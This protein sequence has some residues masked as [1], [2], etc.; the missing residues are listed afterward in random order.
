MAA[1]SLHFYRVIQVERYMITFWR[2]V[3][4]LVK[5]RYRV[6]VLLSAI[7]RI[8]VFT[9]KTLSTVR[10]RSYKNATTDHRRRQ[11]SLRTHLSAWVNHVILKT[12]S[13][14]VGKHVKREASIFKFLLFEDFEERCRKAAFS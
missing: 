3:G 4:W 8:I 1:A 11:E 5:N 6:I 12:S 7:V 13:F 9:L 14:S 10:L 2:G